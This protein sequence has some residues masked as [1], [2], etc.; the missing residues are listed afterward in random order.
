MIH[1]LKERLNLLAPTE[2]LCINAQMVAF[3]GRLTLKQYNLHKPKKWG[4]KLYILTNPV[5]LIYDFEFHIVTIDVCPG[6][7]ELQASGNIVMNLLANFPRHKDCKFFI[8]NWCTRIPLVTTLMN[9]GI[10]LVGA[11]RA[12]KLRNCIM[13]SGKDK[14][15]EGRSTIAIKTC[16]LVVSRYVLSSGLIIKTFLS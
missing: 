8:D 3:K 2:L 6:Q 14:K 4:C 1:A 5:S 16:N 13:L 7:S 9:Q 11:V 10:A 12:K 15:K